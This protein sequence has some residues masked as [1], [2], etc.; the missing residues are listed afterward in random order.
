MIKDL[1]NKDVEH[2]LSQMTFVTRKVKKVTLNNTEDTAIKH[3]KHTIPIGYLVIRNYAGGIV[4]D[5]VASWT[6][7]H[8]YLRASVSGDYEIIII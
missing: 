8:I 2:S 4:Y 6:R 1:T 5:G 3:F 7:E